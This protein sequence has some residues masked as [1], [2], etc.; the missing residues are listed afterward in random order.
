[1]IPAK[2]EN[3]IEDVSFEEILMD[4]SSQIEVEQ[5]KN[6][7]TVAK[8]GYPPTKTKCAPLPLQPPVPVNK[9]QNFEGQAAVSD[10]DKGQNS[11]LDVALFT[12]NEE[13]A[14]FT[15]MDPAA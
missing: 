2:K 8:S 14:R 3:S 1:M 6:F 11:T 15:H 9:L 13:I 7:F 10:A 4:D 5:P 12:N